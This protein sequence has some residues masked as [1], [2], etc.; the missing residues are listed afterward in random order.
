MISLQ[1]LLNQSSHRNL[2]LMARA[3]KIAFTRREAKALGLAKL[4]KA[5]HDGAYKKA[6]NCLNQ[7]HIEALQALVA[8]GDWLPLPLFTHH[9]GEIRRYKPWKQDFYPRHPWRYPAS[10][11]ERLYHLGYIVIRGLDNGGSYICRPTAIQ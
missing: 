4:S 10:V 8:G 9:F 1:D 3:H 2:E 11:A 6:F 7:E 5:L